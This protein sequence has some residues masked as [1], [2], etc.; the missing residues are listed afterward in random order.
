MKKCKKCNKE[1][2]LKCFTVD[3]SKKDNLS[4]KCKQCISEYRIFRIDKIKAYRKYYNE[5]KRVYV[6]KSNR[7][8]KRF[9]SFKERYNNDEL[10]KLAH[11]T[12]DLI[13]KSIN[14][15]GYSKDTK[16]YDIL[17][18]T[19]EFF[20]TY[21]ESQFTKEMNWNNIY[22]DHIY[23]VSLAKTKEEI[24]Q[25]NHYTNFQPLLAIDNLKKSNKIISK[26]FKLL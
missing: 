25:L 5:N 12:R 17:G 3:N 16:T 14:Y 15:K 2:D 4:Y 8:R 10:F 20:K 23:P 22:L 26:Q 7:K 21:L 13:R 1:K 6:N 19:Y 9:K 24:I 18:C 11:K